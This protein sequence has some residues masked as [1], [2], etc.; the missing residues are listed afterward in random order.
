MTS[1][2][3]EV[4]TTET[5][6]RDPRSP[7]LPPVFG[8]LTAHRSRSNQ[9]HNHQLLTRENHSP[10]SGRI[11]VD[12]LLPV[13]AVAENNSN[14]DNHRTSSLN[15][16][17]HH[18]STSDLENFSR[19]SDGEHSQYSLPPPEQ[20]VQADHEEDNVYHTSLTSI[21]RGSSRSAT[22]SKKHRQLRLPPIL[23]PKVYTVQPRELKALEFPSPTKLP[24]PITEAQW[25]DLHDCRYIR[26][27]TPRRSLNL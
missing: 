9:G 19:Q 3:S 26:N 17:R 7:H 12:N 10:A 20:E 23:L 6:P 25:E 15:S 14:N 1:A 27:I 11:S 4:E 22:A 8:H 21:R 24:G 5:V 18:A 16:R 13:F 2:A